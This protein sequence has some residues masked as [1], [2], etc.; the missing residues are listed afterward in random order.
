MGLNFFFRKRFIVTAAAVGLGLA[1]AAAPALALTSIGT[2][3]ST[4]GTLSVAGNATFDT[5][6][7]FVDAANNRVGVGTTSPS[8]PFEVVNN[9]SSN[10]QIMALTKPQIGG[11]G[12][13]DQGGYMVFRGGAVATPVIRGYF[14]FTQT[15]GGQG[16]ILSGASADTMALRAEGDLLFGTG[17]DNRR[18]LITSGG[19]VGVNEMSP[20]AKLT[21]K[22]AGTTSATSSLKVTNST[23][24]AL[25]AVRDDG[26]VGIGTTSPAQKLEIA[27]GNI[28]V[29]RHP[30]GARSSYIGVGDIN[31]SFSDSTAG[32]SIKIQSIADNGNSSQAMHFI[33]HH[34]GV[35]AGIRM[36]I[37][38]DGLVG[39]GTSTPAGKLHVVTATSG[40][41][42]GLIVQNGVSTQTANLQ[43]WR[44]STGDVL[45]K[46]SAGGSIQAQTFRLLG[47]FDGNLANTTLTANR[48]WTFPDATGTVALTSDLS[49][50]A[51]KTVPATVGNF[52]ALNASGNLIDSGR[53]STDFV[54]PTGSGAGLT[55]LNASNIVQGSTSVGF[56]SAAGTA[57]NIDSGTTGNITIGQGGSAKTITIG[58]QVHTLT[59]RGA[60]TNI[61]TIGSAVEAS[62]VN[63][64]NTSNGTGTQTVIIG[65]SAKAANSVVI[66]AGTTGNVSVSGTL[67]MGTN[68]ITSTGSLGSSGSRLTKGWFTDTDVSGNLQVGGNVTVGNHL[69]ATGTAVSSAATG[70]CTSSTISGNDVRGIISGGN[71]ASG[72]TIIVS[73]QSAYS[74]APICVI[75]PVNTTAAAS[76]ASVSPATGSLTVTVQNAAISGIWSYIC[77]Q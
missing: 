47:S 46:V 31:G 76:A 4:D 18:L 27:T 51:D 7:L 34:S 24:G 19:N 32:S 40:S 42:I 26:N 41:E 49:V 11:G 17:G 48:T 29:D 71:C 53:S 37:D 13:N 16:T 1:A 69:A 61:G 39:I 59:L 33:T 5:N 72:A 57:M 28:L 58:S 23:G 73:F 45:A 38:K 15:A 68:D 70:T 50:K 52:A 25:F 30:V 35:S 75:S 20:D 21:V 65:S 74:S 10:A 64:A 55:S 77:I 67:A 36:S 56:Y 63:I 22:G 9:S 62:T 6:T 14:G 3:I 8:A 2:N 43:E 44:N 60:T 12:V 54:T 66:A